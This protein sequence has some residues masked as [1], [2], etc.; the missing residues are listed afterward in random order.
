MI[1]FLS[2]IALSMVIWGCVNNPPQKPN[3]RKV[4]YYIE[5][6]PVGAVKI[7]KTDMIVQKPILKEL[8]LVIG[9]PGAPSGR[10][11]TGNRTL[12]YPSGEKMREEYY[13]DDGREIGIWVSYDKAGNIVEEV[14]K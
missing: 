11:Y 6:W 12:F 9:D 5:Y 10:L 3:Q 14:K 4:Q 1:K 8:A 7:P 2:L 13:S